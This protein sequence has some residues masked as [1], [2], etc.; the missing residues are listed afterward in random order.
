[1][2]CN[3]LKIKPCYWCS[4]AYGYQANYCWIYSH[5]ENIEKWKSENKSSI[6]K[7]S[8]KIWG[9]DFSKNRD[10]IAEWALYYRAALKIV[11]PECL[12]EFDKY[13]VLL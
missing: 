10:V 4:F 5:I 3:D 7:H 2:N 8:L 11:M 13:M 1:M 12:E 9:T 6:V